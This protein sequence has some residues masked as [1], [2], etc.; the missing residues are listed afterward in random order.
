MT[1][2]ILLTF[3][4]HS[5][6]IVI[7]INKISIHIRYSNHLENIIVY[8]NSFNMLNSFIGLKNS[9]VLPVMCLPIILPHWFGCYCNKTI[10]S[11]QRL[12]TLE[13]PPP[14]SLEYYLQLLALHS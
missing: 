1:S 2:E 6:L 7:A 3:L 12:T 14:I 9:Y 4:F 10:T 11:L 13:Q 5:F 8:H